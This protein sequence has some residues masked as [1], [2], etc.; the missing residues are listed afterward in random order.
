MEKIKTEKIIGSIPL[1]KLFRLIGRL[2][3]FSK[4]GIS[5]EEGAVLLEDLA[6]IAAD[7]AGKLAK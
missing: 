7:I 1:V 4:G 5:K 3:A 2:I 6:E